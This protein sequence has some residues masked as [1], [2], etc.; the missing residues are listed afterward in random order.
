MQC[1]WPVSSF[2]KLKH[3]HILFLSQAVQKVEWAYQMFRNIVVPILSDNTGHWQRQ[4]LETKP[5]FER[6]GYVPLSTNKMPPFAPAFWSIAEKLSHVQNSV[7]YDIDTEPI[8]EELHN[9]EIPVL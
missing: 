1:P 3:L 8:T 7:R 2:I 5:Q 9:K 6:R 4:I